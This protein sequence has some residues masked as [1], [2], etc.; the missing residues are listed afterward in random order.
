MTAFITDYNTTFVITLLRNG[1]MVRHFFGN[2]NISIVNDANILNIQYIRAEP[3][4]NAEVQMIR[5]APNE[6]EF[7]TPKINDVYDWHHFLDNMPENGA[8]G[9][10][11]GP[12]PTLEERNL[13]EQARE[14]AYMEEQN[15]MLAG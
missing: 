15:H 1:E 8:M 14:I 13:L 2:H 4:Y 5:I 11:P 6:V 9:G 12:P 3:L 7:L 10:A